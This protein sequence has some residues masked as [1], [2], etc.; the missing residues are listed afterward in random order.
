MFAAQ[1]RL[2]PSCPTYPVCLYDWIYGLSILHVFYCISIVRGLGYLCVRPS[3]VLAPT[4]IVK[5][6]ITKISSMGI[7]D[8]L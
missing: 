7:P 1:L 4:K 3:A 5:K 8:R 2:A 6:K